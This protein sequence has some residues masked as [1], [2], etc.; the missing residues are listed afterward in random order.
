MLRLSYKTVQ[1]CKAWK[2]KGDIEADLNISTYRLFAFFHVA[3]E[4]TS[5]MGC[6]TASYK[7]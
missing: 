3:A 5:F 4:I 2:V 7:T 6:P 1:G